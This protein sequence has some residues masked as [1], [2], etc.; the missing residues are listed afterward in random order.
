MAYNKL[1]ERGQS[2][3]DLSIQ[4]YGSVLAMPLM[5]YD[6][7]LFPW[8][9]LQVGQKLSFRDKGQISEVVIEDTTTMD[10]F[11]DNEIRVNCHESFTIGFLL[12]LDGGYLL[13][14][15]GSKIILSCQTC[16]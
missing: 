10:Y 9:A 2:P 16:L 12:N 3:I 15:D 6:N 13:Q 14:K 8:P 4:E 7:G 5:E 1:I 11:R